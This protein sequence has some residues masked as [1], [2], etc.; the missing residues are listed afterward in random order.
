MLHKSTAGSRIHDK[1]DEANKDLSRAIDLF[2]HDGHRS[3]KTPE[4]RVRIQASMEMFT[5]DFLGEDYDVSNESFKETIIKGFNAIVE[6]LKKVLVYVIDFFKSFMATNIKS[7]ES[8]VRKLSSN[9]NI[10]LSNSLLLENI[11]LLGYGYT[12]KIKGKSV[13][14]VRKFVSPI[15]SCLEISTEVLRSTHDINKNIE[16]GITKDKASQLTAKVNAI[17][18]TISAIDAENTPKIDTDKG[19]ISFNREVVAKKFSETYPRNDSSCIVNVPAF[20]S[21]F[22]A[23]KSDVN[24]MSRIIKDFDSFINDLKSA[25][26]SISSADAKRDSS[27]SASDFMTDVM[28]LSSIAL[29]FQKYFLEGLNQSIRFNN[30]VVKAIAFEYLPNFV[31]LSTDGLAASL[32]GVKVSVES[33]GEEIPVIST[34]AVGSDDD[35]MLDI[36]EDFIIADD[37]PADM[38]FELPEEDEVE[39]SLEAL[40]AVIDEGPTLSDKA[41]ETISKVVDKI[42]ELAKKVYV[43]I[44][45][46]VYSVI[47]L[48]HKTLNNEYTRLEMAR[49]LVLIT[50]AVKSRP[51]TLD[52][53]SSTAPY[54]AFNNKGTL[55]PNQVQKRIIYAGNCI[56]SIKALMESMRHI[57]PHG[58]RNTKVKS[59]IKNIGDN[60]S[61]YTQ[62]FKDTGI[63]FTLSA[64]DEL[65]VPEFTVVNNNTDSSVEVGSV[66]LKML[67]TGV[68]GQ[69]GFK[70]IRTT[71]IVLNSTTRSLKH[72]H[73]DT[74]R[75]NRLTELKNKL[76]LK[77]PEELTEAQQAI[78]LTRIITSRSLN[79]L[80]FI[81]RSIIAFTDSLLRIAY[82]VY[83]GKIYDGAAFAAMKAKDFFKK[84]VGNEGFK[85]IENIRNNVLESLE[86]GGLNSHEAVAV[87]IAAPYLKDKF[88]I[89]DFSIEPSLFIDPRYR[90]EFTE[91]Y[92]DK[93]S[94]I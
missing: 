42:V 38:V 65:G 49:K 81:Y 75:K 79:M 69:T 70:G 93:L 39:A 76:L 94:N 54:G 6:K 14:T 87:N 46:K 78:K 61:D 50:S 35:E 44:R 21:S 16:S 84:A 15:R 71:L 20:L 7:T 41:K 26:K 27:F 23:Y 85:E 59:L 80:K 58:V 88:G 53:T 64:D 67:A 40:P 22:S 92:L 83:T 2:Q 31:N 91:L 73:E 19:T 36:D 9:P 60:F 28:R 13:V 30:T 43:W 10:K 32:H 47:T 82:E 37:E 68:G 8:L 45:E 48:I 11:N 62:T 63:E 5:E 51:I 33:T 29:E 25:I 77:A 17:V 74:G 4:E 72:L 1:L 34:I 52:F 86:R 12:E 24:L 57:D 18:N 3:A 89:E 66:D 56:G 90:K 55:I